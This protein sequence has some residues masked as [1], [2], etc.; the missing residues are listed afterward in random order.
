MTSARRRQPSAETRDHNGLR[1]NPC[2]TDTACTL[3]DRCRRRAQRTVASA[4]ILC[5]LLVAATAGVSAQG[6]FEYQPVTAALFETYNPQVAI[7][8]WGN[9][10]LM[11]SSRDPRRSGLQLFYSHNGTGRF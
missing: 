11:W 6:V 4:M 10:H 2:D 7:D 5:A 9:T 8:N 1:L 3:N